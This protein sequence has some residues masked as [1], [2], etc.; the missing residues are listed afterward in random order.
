M[1]S[2]SAPQYQGGGSSHVNPT[3]VDSHSTSFA[4][5][6]ARR[7]V[8]YARGYAKRSDAD[9]RLLEEA[10]DSAAAAD[11]AVVFVGLYEEDQSEGFDRDI[12]DLPRR[13]ST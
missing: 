7:T 10:V 4:T 11:V 8:T 6:S 2:P 3:R 12:I 1:S 5:H 9:P 13:T